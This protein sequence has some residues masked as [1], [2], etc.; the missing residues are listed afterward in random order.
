VKTLTE[1]KEDKVHLG[2]NQRRI[3]QLLKK[4]KNMTER[5]IATEVYGEPV[6]LG[7][8]RYIATSRSL[9]NLLKR[10]LVLKTTQEVKWRLNPKEEG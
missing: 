8:Y 4:R 1:N 9:Q 6:K 10:G 5:E 3:L 7:D 2:P